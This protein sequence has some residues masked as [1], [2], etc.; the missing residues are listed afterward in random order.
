MPD[1]WIGNS[2][3]AKDTKL[4]EGTRPASGYGVR[5]P[6]GQQLGRAAARTWAQGSVRAR[7]T[8]SILGGAGRRE[9]GLPERFVK[10]SV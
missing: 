8:A 4:R 1:D 9:A 2:L 7:A 6:G 5:S 3:L 10:Y